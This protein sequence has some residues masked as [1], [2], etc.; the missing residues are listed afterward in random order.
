MIENPIYGAY[1]YGKSRAATG[2]DGTAMRRR[3]HRKARDEWPA[4]IPGSH[5]GYV[6]WERSEDIRKMVS[7]NVP[8][9]RHHGAPK[10]GDGLLAGLV[11]CRRCGRKLTVRYTGAKHDIPRYSCWRG[12]L[13][14][15]IHRGCSDGLAGVA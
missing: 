4:L 11:R 9:G 8:I 5:E 10:H 12:L 7:D 14:R 6:S 2:Y 13:A 3:S 15:L 1:A